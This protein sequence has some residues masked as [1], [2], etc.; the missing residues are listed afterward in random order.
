M[1]EK[2]LYLQVAHKLKIMLQRE[3]DNINDFRIIAEHTNQIGR[4]QLAESFMMT[5]NQMNPAICEQEDLI[6][7]LRHLDSM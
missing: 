3:F 7:E 2:R 1:Q 6:H 4:S 5:A